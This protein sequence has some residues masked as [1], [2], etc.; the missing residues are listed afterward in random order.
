MEYISI[1]IY[2]SILSLTPL[3]IAGIGELVCE[4]AGVLNLGIEGMMLVGAIS[5]FIATAVTGNVFF[6]FLMA[7]VSGVLMSSIFA[8]LTI[9]LRTNQ[10]ATGL[11]LT[12]FG[13]GLSAFMGLKYVGVPITGLGKL[14]IPLL[15]EI[16]FFG[17]ILFQ[18][19][20]LVYMAFMLLVGTHFF[21]FHTRLGL[22]LRAVG[23]NHN[24]AYS[25]GYS[26]LKIRFL[27][28]I[29]GGAMAGL[30]GSYLSLVYTPLW[31]ENM[32]AGRG[33]IVLALV[34]FST[35]LPSRLLIGAFLFG[36]VSI[37]QL[38]LQGNQGIF[39][40]IPAE[41]FAMLPY[42]TTIIVL[43]FIS[44]IK[45]KHSFGAPSNL[46]VPFEAK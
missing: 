34:V 28:V 36:F 23:E 41:F 25:M 15:A 24:S 42:L 12:I 9:L 10:V 8:T 3:L 46:G 45:M 29:F 32:T 20:F 43:I 4:K 16:P 37:S 11:A 14:N 44:S 7:T 39:S 27:A 18:H 13:V 40:Q 26:I 2:A 5:G 19:D 35:W 22:I 31:A 38:F 33:W 21:L 6:G 17:K 30:G 1:I